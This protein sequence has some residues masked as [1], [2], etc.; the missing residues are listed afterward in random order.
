MKIAIYGR[1]FS[2]ATL[3]YVQQVFD[4]LLHFGIEPLVF[5]K[6]SLFISGKVFYP[7]QFQTFASYNDI[8]GR[9]D[10]LISLG[11]DGTMLDTVTLIRDS[12][13]PII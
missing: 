2:S 5:E 6:F 13:I 1:E 3:P 7:S 4:C 12:E 11:G 8:K 10:V 9:A